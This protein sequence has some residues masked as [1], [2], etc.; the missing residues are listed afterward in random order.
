MLSEAAACK[1]MGQIKLEV[2]SH[3]ADSSLCPVLEP[4]PDLLM[5]AGSDMF[6]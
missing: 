2:V 4:K 1:Q 6:K 3:F 5:S